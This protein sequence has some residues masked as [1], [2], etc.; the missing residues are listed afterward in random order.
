MEAGKLS[1]KIVFFHKEKTITESGAQQV[2]D[3]EIL[4]TRFADVS[5]KGSTGEEANEIQYNIMRVVLLRYNVKITKDCTC[6]IDDDKYSIDSIIV[7]RRKNTIKLYLKNID[8]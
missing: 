5:E 8:K 4:H 1:N 6:V 3:K 7:N 2:E